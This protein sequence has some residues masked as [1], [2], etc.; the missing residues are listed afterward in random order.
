MSHQIKTA[1]LC[2]LSLLVC[3]TA[4][5]KAESS[6]KGTR[7]NV[8]MI[9]PDDLGYGSIP[10]YGGRK[11]SPNIDKLYHLGMRF[12]DFH[13]SPTCAPTR[14]ALLTGRNECYAGVTHTIQMRDRM[15]PELRLVPH[16]LKDVGYTTGIFGKWH[17]G[18]GPEFR[19]DQR[20]FDETYIHGAG[21]I[22]QNYDHSADFPNN[23][24][25]NPVLYHNGQ[26]VETTGYCT[27]LFF[28]QAI[29][30]M[31]AQQKAGKPF[32]CFITPNV[33]H[34]PKIPPILPD[35]SV[36]DIMEN[37]DDN[38]GK[39]TRFLERAG[40]LEHTLYI[41]MTDNGMKP[42]GRKNLKGGKASAWEGGTRVP[43]FMYWKGKIEGGVEC[44]KLTGHID[45][46][47]T[48]ADLAGSD[49][50]VPGGK[51]WDG[52]SLLPLFE[53]PDSE[54]PNRYWVSHRTRWNDKERGKY[55]Q[56][57]IRD[58]RFKLI[59][60]KP[61]APE[62]YDLQADVSETT[63]VIS[64]HPEVAEQLKKQFEAWWTDVVPHMINDDLPNVP[65]THKPF[66]ELYREAMGEEKYEAAMKAMTWTGGK[67]SE[68]KSK[69]KRA[70][71]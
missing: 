43:C 21:G 31:K 32:F 38:V 4:I 69:Q 47:A 65:K 63:N 45:Y 54:W 68:K 59:Y 37:L 62:L 26:V 41:Y 18:D 5:V 49:D 33:N 13:A 7:P 30:W 8:V 23:D 71:K 11:P 2:G 1:V 6:L 20:G 48:F 9:M 64:Q 53:N 51:A 25:N 19:P 42:S 50:P 16:M 39:M 46:Y 29:R 66:H 36:G 15:N 12:E 57:A 27:D 70:K 35:G 44:H 52:R 17:L 3:G 60:Q 10:G 34:S 61:N 40:L 56:G 58:E 55:A 24:Y 14:A 67:G 28:D 22:G